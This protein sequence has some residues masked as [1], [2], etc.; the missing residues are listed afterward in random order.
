MPPVLATDKK[1]EKT[2]YVNP[3]A[4]SGKPYKET[5]LV[6]DVL[7]IRALQARVD[8]DSGS[9]VDVGRAEGFADKMRAGEKFPPIKLMAVEDAPGHKGTEVMVCWDGMHT[10]FAAEIAKLKDID[11]LVWKGT[12]AQ[13]LMAAA[14]VAN[15]EHDKNGRPLSTKDKQHSLDLL[16][17]SFKESDVPKKDWPSNRKLAEMTGLSHQYIN[18]TDPFEKGKGDQ[19]GVKN[20]KKRIDREKLKETPV[21]DPV[22]NSPVTELV[23]RKDTGA[24]IASYHADTPAKALDR[25]KIEYPHVPMSDVVTKAVETTSVKAGSE[26]PSGFDWA[27]MDERM[28]YLI[29]GL[30]G[31]AS[32]HDLKKT[33]GYQLAFNGID[34]FAK[35]FNAWRKEFAKSKGKVQ[36]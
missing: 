12:W 33:P 30:D 23:V 21:L 36:K 16:V 11:A 34:Q 29:R 4:L 14:T 13:A 20:I 22:T 3:L 32:L 25:F 2:A 15:R 1:T 6:K 28:G 19:R 27:G 18:D 31:L 10:H 8:V 5:P 26:K 7:R 24:V 9:E 35:Q 17:R